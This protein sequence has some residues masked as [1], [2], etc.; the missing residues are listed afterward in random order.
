MANVSLKF[1][2][3]SFGRGEGV[4]LGG[5]GRRVSPKEVWEEEGVSKLLVSGRDNVDSVFR[6]DVEGFGESSLGR[7][8]GIFSSAL[9]GLTRPVTPLAITCGWT[10][11]HGTSM[12]RIPIMLCWKVTRDKRI[13]ASEAKEPP[14]LCPINTTS[15]VFNGR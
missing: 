11:S 8:R 10:P 1:D 12:P 7:S 4:R 15:K 3:F 2:F 5:G 13:S 14:I 6:L 9:L